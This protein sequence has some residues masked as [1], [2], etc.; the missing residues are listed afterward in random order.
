M[1][2]MLAVRRGSRAFG[3]GRL[4]FLKPGNRKILAYLRELDGEAILCV[5]NLSRAAQAVELDLARYK[6]R[7]PVELLGRSAFPPIGELPYMLTIPAHGF[8]WFRLATDVEVPR[9]HEDRPG[10]EDLPILVLFDGWNSLFRDRVVPWRIGM[11]EKTRAQ[12]ESE[13]LPRHIELQRWYAGKGTA[14]KRARLADHALWEEGKHQW[15]VQILELDGPPGNP[16]YFL[17]LAL[18]WEEREEERLRALTA[19]AVVKV[20]QQANVGVMGDAFADETFCRAL[21]Q[22]I[23][24]SKVI[25]TA[26]GKLQFRP[27]AAFVEL[28]GADIE[29]LPVSRQQAQSSNTLVTLGERL[30]LKGYRRLQRGVNPEFEI[31]RF[32]TE[33][34]KFPNCVP[35]AGTLEYVDAGGV[36]MTLALVQA[37]VTNQGDAW[38]YTLDYLGRYLEDRR[39]NVTAE[40]VDVHGAYVALIRI[41]GTR[42]AELHRAFARP[43]I[44][45]AFA[46]EPLTDADLAAYRERIEGEARATLRLLEAGLAQ[47]PEAARKI[48]DTVLAAQ[49]RLMGRIA[50][51]IPLRASG[52]KTRFHGDFHLGQALLTKNDFLIIDFEG[53]PGR[54]FDERRAKQPPMRDV[55]G[56]LRSFNYARWGALRGLVAGSID[57]ERLAPLVRA[58]EIEV[59]NA[60]ISAY[61]AAAGQHLSAGPLQSGQG[62]LGLFELEKALY[63]LRYELANRPDWVPIPLLGILELLDAA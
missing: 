51:F 44:D 37:Y 29:Q 49:D 24:A 10:A 20:R 54:A 63:E 28:A 15:L 35:L 16:A 48:A 39:V 47:L 11:A 46:P 38:A 57:F 52:L 59:R 22:A 26:H 14:I 6:T 21:V 60:F 2:R 50:A 56:M 18:A 42:A 53:E 5:T 19:A 58:W 41:L 31:G 25:V 3:R 33:V 23:G 12:F 55:A 34:A 62:L 36:V 8:Y 61:N 17:P 27:T 32:L 43:G 9:W 40:P 45:A 4:S 1:K 7:V 13:A 30:L